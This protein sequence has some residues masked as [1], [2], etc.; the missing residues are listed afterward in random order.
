MTE[1]LSFSLF[2]S[3]VLF[4]VKP[5]AFILLAIS[6]F[7]NAMTV[8]FIVKILSYISLFVDPDGFSSESENDWISFDNDFLFN[9]PTNSH[10]LFLLAVH[11]II[12]PVPLVDLSVLP[13]VFS[14]A[15]YFVVHEFPCVL[16]F[17][18]EQ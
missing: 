16:A 4:A 5:L 2:T 13:E 3:T 9:Q 8:L 12:F 10:P 7:E 6:P 11:F 17:I 1:S 18:S 14:E 15:R